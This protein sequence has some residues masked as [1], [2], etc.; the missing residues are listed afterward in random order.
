M[1]VIILLDYLGVRSF[2]VV[3]LSR[4]APIGPIIILLSLIGILLSL[5][6]SQG[7]VHLLQSHYPIPHLLDQC[8][9]PCLLLS[10]HRYQL[11]LVLQ[12]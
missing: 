11:F 2:T 12:I 3:K 6:L 4:L 10:G 7:L 9:Q 1:Y 8:I 5:C